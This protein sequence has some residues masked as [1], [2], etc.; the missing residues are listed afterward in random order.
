MPFRRQTSEARNEPAHELARERNLRQHD[1]GLPAAPQ[2]LG[3]RFEVDFRFAGPRHA[4]E[5]RDRIAATVNRRHERMHRFG[6][7]PA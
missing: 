5:Q 4:V 7:R 1:H 6:L 3:H 2:R